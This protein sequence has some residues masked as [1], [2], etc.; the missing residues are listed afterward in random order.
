MSA[1]LTEARL[2][3]ALTLTE[4]ATG[5]TRALAGVVHLGHEFAPVFR[6]VF[7]DGL[8]VVVKTPRPPDTLHPFGSGL[9]FR[10]EQAALALV[11]DTNLA[12]VL[13]GADDDVGVLVTSDLGDS[14]LDLIIRGSDRERAWRAMEGYGASMGRLHALTS[15]KIDEYAAERTR[16][17]FPATDAERAGTWTGLDAWHDIETACLALR[18]PDA[19]HVRDDI[20]WLR[21]SIIEDRWTALAHG[22]LSPWNTH[23]AAD[24][25][26]T[27]VDFEGATFGHIGFD[28]SWIH[29]PFT[30]CSDR[31][32]VLPPDIVTATEDA[33]R[34]ELARTLPA[35]RD[36]SAF[37]T[38]IAVGAAGALL[39]RLQRLHLLAS[40]GQ[41]SYDSWRRRTQTAHQLDVFAGLA[42][43]AGC[44]PLLAR[45]CQ[46]LGFA[47][48][49]R[50]TDCGVPPAPHFAAF[51]PG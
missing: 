16:L 32:S 10:R 38:M 43:A 6:L 28:A 48:R 14:V 15:R 29:Y 22:D 7:V 30:N 27:F 23:V 12:P 25:T 18:L 36:D 40:D 50:W 3:R 11:Q 1:E 31:W 39:V 26:V 4:E 9:S 46:D 13:V 20:A 44:V 2:A 49:S 8:S 41:T 33:Y 35:A 24:D 42:D 37:R 17:D 5:V 21:D 45:W 51:E 34:A 47:M 19:R